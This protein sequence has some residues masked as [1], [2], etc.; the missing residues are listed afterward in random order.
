MSLSRPTRWLACL[1]VVFAAL[2]AR[3]A[4]YYV[5]VNG[6]DNAAGSNAAPFATLERAQTAAQP[7]DT[8][9]VHGGVYSF[10]GTSRTVGVSFTKDGLANRPIHY[11]AVP[12]ETPIFDFFNLLPQARVTGFDVNCDW[13]HIR[14]LEV[15]GV[16]QIIVGD[17]WGV[18]VRGSNNVIE[19]VNSH[20]H[21]APGF[22]ITSGS[23]NLISNCDSHHNYDPLEGGGNADGFGCH[24]S[25]GANV[26][27]G[28]RG[29]A[30]S[31]DGYDFINAA[32]SCTV[33]RSFAFNNGFIPDTTVAAGN[34]AGFKAG[35]YGLD[36]STFPAPV[37]RHVVR[38]NVAFGNRAQGFYANHHP[39]GIDFFNNT[40]FR[41]TINYNMLADVGASSHTLRN[42]VAL[43][44][45]GTISNLTGGTA[46]FNS[47]NLPVTVSTADFASVTESQV[48][49]ARGADGS[50][51]VTT[52]MRLA[53]GS[54]L[55]DKGTNV[56]L[57]FVGTAP[58]LGAFEFGANGATCSTALGHTGSS[59]W[60]LMSLLCV[61][62]LSARRLSARSTVR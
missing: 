48:L 54:D 46:S 59:G 36:P 23:G 16:Q 26:I 5:A 61:A 49:A 40:A 52:F 33:E 2:P 15:R 10:S 45:G 17:S 44:P 1:F 42:N 22:F 9:F 14:G 21:E 58:D 13:I 55:I 8:V 39:G 7:G 6:N 4:A 11:F 12:G 34:G 56:G 43:A 38:M 32:G 3:A 47:W 51:P 57:P 31:D 27:S 18:R 37:P 20:H 25:G 35:G 53:P 60:F 50:L 29:Y 28:C 41:N 62:T 30:N 24:S 19:A